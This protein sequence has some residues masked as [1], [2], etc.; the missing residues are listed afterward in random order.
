[1]KTV[2]LALFLT[3]CVS[4]PALPEL[5]TEDGSSEE[6]DAGP[7]QTTAPPVTGP[8]GTSSTT[9]PTT[10]GSSSDNDGSSESSSGEPSEPEVLWIAEPDGDL[11]G[12]RCLDVI[13]DGEGGAVASFV[14]DPDSFGAGGLVL[15]LSDSGDETAT[16][17]LDQHQ[18]EGL[19]RAGVGAFAWVDTTGHA[20][21]SSTSLDDLDGVALGG[22]IWAV[23]DVALTDS[24]TAYSVITGTLL[25]ECRIRHGAVDTDPY[26]C[27]DEWDRW[28]IEPDGDGVAGALVGNFGL[29]RVDGAGQIAAV[30]DYRYQRTVLDLAVGQNNEVWTVGGIGNPDEPG[31]T[32]GAFVA[33]HDADLAEEPL[34]EGVEDG[35]TS[36]VWT[37]IV[38]DDDAPILIGRDADNEPRVTALTSSGDLAWTLYLDLSS[39]SLL[40]HADL[41]DTGRLAICGERG[42]APLVLSVAVP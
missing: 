25:P 41:D 40:R 28:R 24:G 35:D 4:A 38:M 14:T 30:L 17:V 33:R 42:S 27:G 31:P 29:V 9:G 11:L 37:G 36:L 16:R 13:A 8:D 3:A 20:G 23:D 39:S 10:S 1:M 2:P 32:Y 34:W 5:G 18:I 26:F 6:S 7:D 12:G 19:E 21:Q 15:S 22:G